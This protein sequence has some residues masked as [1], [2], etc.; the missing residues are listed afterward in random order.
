MHLLLGTVQLA[1]H[2]GNCARRRLLH[3]SAVDDPRTPRCVS[4]S[5]R[6]AVSVFPPSIVFSFVE[7]TRS[8][9]EQSSPSTPHRP[10]LAAPPRFFAPQATA[11]RPEPALPFQELGRALCRP[12]RTY[13]RRSPLK[14]HAELRPPRRATSSGYPPPQI[15]PR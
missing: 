15:E 2:T 7:L 13:R 10:F 5:G 6:G 1:G 3:A 9:D 12:N 8:Q 4:L 11:P 14:L